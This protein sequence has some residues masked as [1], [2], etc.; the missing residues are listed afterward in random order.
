MSRAAGRFPSTLVRGVLLALCV[1]TCSAAPRTFVASFGN[2]AGPCS[3][4]QPC[5][6]FHTALSHTDAGGELI[7]LD[8]GGYGSVSISQSVSIIAPAGIYAGIS[9]LSGNG[10]TVNGSGIKVVLRGLTINGQGGM[11]GVDFV[12]GGTLLVEDCQIGNFSAVGGIGIND[13]AAN[14]QLTV[15]HTALRQSWAG[16]NLGPAALY[17]ML[18]DI[19][20]SYVGRG[21]EAYGG[22]HVTVTNSVISGAQY[23]VFAASTGPETQVTVRDSTIAGAQQGFL[24]QAIGA[25]AQAIVLSDG[26][27]ID[28]V[29]NAFAFSG[30]GGAEVITTPGNNTVGF[31]DIASGAVSG[32]SLTSVSE[33]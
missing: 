25:S 6:S 19:R 12:Q 13:A 3:R 2:D 27:T 24:V 33:Y 14:S 10:V 30:S 26:N 20:V 31:F 15:K 9:V 29:T 28:Q 11:L 18:D 16:V 22:S 17:A 21:V 8:S 1:G 7:V 23:G 32:G 4:T 5:R